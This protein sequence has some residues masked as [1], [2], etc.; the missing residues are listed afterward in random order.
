MDR[1]DAEQASRWFVARSEAAARTAAAKALHCS[2]SEVRYMFDSSLNKL[3]SYWVRC[4]L[5]IIAVLFAAPQSDAWHSFDSRCMAGIPRLLHTY[6]HSLAPR[7]R[8]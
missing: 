8:S 4:Q 1:N 6:A 2:E 7:T 5:A 3:L